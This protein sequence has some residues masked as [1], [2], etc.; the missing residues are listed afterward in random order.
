M[1]NIISTENIKKSGVYKIINT[2]TE[3]YY[4]GS[5]VNLYHRICQHYHKLRKNIHGN[6]RLQN[7]YNKYGENNFQVLIVSYEDSKN[8]RKVEYDLIEKEKPAYNLVNIFNE[9]YFDEKVRLKMSN[10]QKLLQKTGLN[11][12]ESKPVEC[13]D[14]D[15]N[16]VKTFNSMSLALKE[17]GKNNSCGAQ[18]IGKCIRKERMSAYGLQWKLVDDPIKITPLSFKGKLNAIDGKKIITLADGTT[19]TDSNS[20]VKYFNKQIVSLCNGGE[21]EICL[22]IKVREVPF[23]SCELLENPEMDNQQPS[24]T[25]M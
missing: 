24:S 5:S 17:L 4:I 15:G 21:V 7:S 22:N 18:Q 19:F 6:S 2:I 23:K 20:L 11:N 3:D 14:L 12:H 25:E 13:Y 16:Y 10:S 9:Y 8:V 1:K